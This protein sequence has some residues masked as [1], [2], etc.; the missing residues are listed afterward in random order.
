MVGRPS[1]GPSVSL[2]VLSVVR[3]TPLLRVC[4]CGPGDQEISIG[5]EYGKTLPL[6]CTVVRGCGVGGGGA[7]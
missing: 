2:S 7:G 1:V 4:C 6:Y 3:H 5:D